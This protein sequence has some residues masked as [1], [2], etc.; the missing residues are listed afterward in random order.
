MQHHQDSHYP[1][2][3]NG[4]CECVVQKKLNKKEKNT[5][6]ACYDGCRGRETLAVC[7][8]EGCGR[9]DESVRFQ[10]GSTGTNT[11]GKPSFP[12]LDSEIYRF[13]V[14]DPACS[15]VPPFPLYPPVTIVWLENYG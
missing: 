11:M 8:K 14:A 2:R 12:A 10:T 3:R 6:L 7:G 13:P 9:N 1:L 4:R 15:L 5:K